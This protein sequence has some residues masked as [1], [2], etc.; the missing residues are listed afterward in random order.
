MVD[1]VIKP[2]PLAWRKI[3]VRLRPCT[4]PIF[5]DGEPTD[6]DRE[7][8][9]ELFQALDPESQDWY[10]HYCPALFAGL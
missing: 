9:R 1:V 3:P 8:A 4:F 2:M 7:L 5:P 6:A 10:R